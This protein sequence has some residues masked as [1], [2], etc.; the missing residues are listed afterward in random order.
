MAILKTKIFLNIN[1]LFFPHKYSSLILGNQLKHAPTVTI[2]YIKKISAFKNM[3]IVYSG[4]P[5][6]YCKSFRTAASNITI[7]V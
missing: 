1:D 6:H 2:K 4:T 7:L 3:I 5:H